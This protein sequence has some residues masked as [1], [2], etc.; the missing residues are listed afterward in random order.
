MLSAVVGG[1]LV[2]FEEEE[3]GGDN[4]QLS[5][6]RFQARKARSG[7]A[8]HEAGAI[9]DGFQD[10]SAVAVGG[11]SPFFVVG[12]LAFELLLSEDGF[13]SLRHGFCENRDSLLDFYT[14][15]EGDPMVLLG[16]TGNCELMVLVEGSHGSSLTLVC[17]AQSSD[18]FAEPKFAERPIRF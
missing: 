12:L 11:G 15:N 2:I 16:R 8:V 4:L 1:W 7:K 5:E 6:A 18:T 10:M 9:A 17:N 13:K 3:V 14:S